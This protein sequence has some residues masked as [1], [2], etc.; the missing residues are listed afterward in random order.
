ML[1]FPGVFS[2]VGF[3]V[4]GFQPGVGIRSNS[5][6]RETSEFG[7]LPLAVVK[8]DKSR[9]FQLQGA[10]GDMHDVEIDHF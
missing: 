5:S 10:G 9:D 8:G 4:N 1:V 3:G 2:R 7:E 6:E